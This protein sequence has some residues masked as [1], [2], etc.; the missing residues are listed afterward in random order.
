MLLNLK[1]LKF[2]T[3]QHYSSIK[4]NGI[5]RAHKLVKKNIKQPGVTNYPLNA[6]LDT[7]NSHDNFNENIDVAIK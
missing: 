1:I 7:S 6:T 5:G 3:K 2:A 4:A